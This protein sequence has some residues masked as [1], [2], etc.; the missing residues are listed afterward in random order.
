[1]IRL[2][3]EA[4]RLAMSKQDEANAIRFSKFIIDLKLT[5]ENVDVPD[6][7][8]RRLCFHSDAAIKYLKS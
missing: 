4:F 8:L 3:H 6:R 5:S 2:I 1:M 7:R